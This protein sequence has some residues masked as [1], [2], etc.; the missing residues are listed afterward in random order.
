M[1]NN[2]TTLDKVVRISI[3]AG[4]LIVALS[5]A[6]YLVIFLP[7]KA[8]MTLEKQAQEQQ[9]RKE[10]SEF[11]LNKSKEQFN[12]VAVSYDENGKKFVP[13]GNSKTGKT[14]D[15]Y[16]EEDYNKYFIRCLQEKGLAN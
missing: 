1:E 8:K 2:A 15:G 14:Y 13:I 11:S 9:L 5:V 7:Q 16:Y 4:A 3:I 6:Y 10:C 12:K